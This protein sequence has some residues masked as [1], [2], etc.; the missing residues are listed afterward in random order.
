MNLIAYLKNNKVWF[1]IIEKR[2]TVHTADAAAATGIPLERVT[3]SLVF[4]ADNSPVLVIIPGNCKVNKT[5]LKEILNSKN[6]EIAPFEKVEEY[7]GYEPG[8]TCPVFHRNIK[9][10]VIDIKVMQHET[11]FG[12]GGSRTKLIELKPEDIQKL[13]NAIVADIAEGKDIAE[14]EK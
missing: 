13:N 3:K 9:K 11:V 1:K 14:V 2:E 7:S 12:G 5:K 10:V 4:L 6:V 8:A